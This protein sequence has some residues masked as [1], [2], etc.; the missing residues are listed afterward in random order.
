MTI[1]FTLY[2]GGPGTGKTY[3]L[4]KLAQEKHAH[5]ISPTW[6]NAELIGGQTIY[7]WCKCTFVKPH[8]K[9]FIYDTVLIDEIFMFGKKQM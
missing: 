5:I 6:A 2:V 7:A 8:P 4:K 9:A 1:T 3:M